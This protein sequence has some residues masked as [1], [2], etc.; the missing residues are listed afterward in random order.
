MRRFPAKSSQPQTD[1]QARAPSTPPAALPLQD[2]NQPASASSAALPA[3]S[4]SSIAASNVRS[5]NGAS[6]AASAQDSSATEGGMGGNGASGSSSFATDSL[7]PFKYSKELM[8]S[9]YK[10]TGLPI[11][12]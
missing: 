6:G 4:Y 8:L 3:F 2:W 12:F 5:Q 7:N 11:E 9:L 1:V 10:P